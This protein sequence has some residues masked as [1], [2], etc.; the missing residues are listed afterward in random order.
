[1]ASFI[2]AFLVMDGV[3]T[4]TVALLPAKYLVQRKTL[5]GRIAQVV[6]FFGNSKS[7]TKKA[8]SA[9][10]EGVA[11]AVLINSPRDNDEEIN[12]LLS[13]VESSDE[14]E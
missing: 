6:E 1:M 3:D 7:K 12:S 9:S 2:A 13:D 14:E 5:E 11:I 8:F 4:C 10:K